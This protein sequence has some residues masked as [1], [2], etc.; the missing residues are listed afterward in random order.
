MLSGPSFRSDLIFSI[1]SLI[2]S[3]FPL[4]SFHLA[5]ASLSAF[6]DF[7]LLCVQLSKSITKKCLL[8]IIIHI[9]SIQTMEQQIMEQQPH[10]ACERTKSKLKQNQERHIQIDHAFYCLI[11]PTNN[12]MVSLKSVQ[13]QSKDVQSQKKDFLSII[14][15]Q[16]L[17]Q[18]DAW[19]WCKSN[20][21]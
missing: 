4:T 20:F 11:Q 14:Y 5:E 10:R 13:R 18:Y 15:N 3:G 17:A 19:S 21:L 6:R 12:G 2:L 16:Y 8:F 1:N 7:I 9:F